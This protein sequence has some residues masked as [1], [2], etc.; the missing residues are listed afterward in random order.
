MLL[1]SL[2]YQRENSAIVPGGL[3]TGAVACTNTAVVPDTKSLIA[4]WIFEI[5]VF[6]EVILL[7]IEVTLLSKDVCTFATS[8]FIE[9]I[10]MSFALSRVTKLSPV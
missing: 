5:F 1:S 9:L 10:S 2:S 4:V 3:S 6:I 8:V 7:F